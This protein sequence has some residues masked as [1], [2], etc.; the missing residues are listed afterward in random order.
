MPD[1]SITA[2][3]AIF[4]GAAIATIITLWLSP[5]LCRW[6]AAH[7]LIHAGGVEAYWKHRQDETEA[8]MK[9]CG[10]PVATREQTA[11]AAYLAVTGEEMEAIDE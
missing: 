3:F 4:G 11:R 6:V 5:A 9:D 2:L 8:R 10:V 1:V 7:L